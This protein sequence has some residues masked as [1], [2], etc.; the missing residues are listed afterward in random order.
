[1]DDRLNLIGKLK[2]V[3][4]YECKTDAEIKAINEAITLLSAEPL[5]DIE[6]RIFL[7]AMSKEEKVCRKVDKEV[8]GDISL[9]HVCHEIE[10]KVKGTLWS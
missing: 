2:F 8:D 4:D 10:R 5:T 1:M 6:Q 7:A 9:T 3:R